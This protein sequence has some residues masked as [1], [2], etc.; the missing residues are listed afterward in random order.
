[1]SGL[2]VIFLSRPYS[3]DVKELISLVRTRF[4]Y[5]FKCINASTYNITI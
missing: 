1:M 2:Y 3:M 4:Y 5:F